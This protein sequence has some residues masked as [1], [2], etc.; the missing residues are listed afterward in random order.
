MHYTRARAAPMQDKYAKV[1]EL[2]PPTL[3]AGGAAA[4][5]AF[6]QQPTFADKTQLSHGLYSIG[7]EQLGQVIM[8]LDQKCP[9]SIER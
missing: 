7:Q 9:Q 1:A 4:G 5:G 8:R 3:G 2:E 6:Q